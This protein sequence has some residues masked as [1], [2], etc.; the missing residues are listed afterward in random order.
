MLG[1]KNPK[2]SEKKK[3]ENGKVQVTNIIRENPKSVFPVL[4]L[5]KSFLCLTD[6]CSTAKVTYIV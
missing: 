5:Y 6:S 3:V 4:L 2:E 1:E